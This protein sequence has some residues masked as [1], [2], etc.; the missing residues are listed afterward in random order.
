MVYDKGVFRGPFSGYFVR[1]PPIHCCLRTKV[2]APLSNCIVKVQCFLKYK[3][4]IFILYYNSLLY[5][6]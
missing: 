4:V 1:L 3:N 2:K 6:V 5:K